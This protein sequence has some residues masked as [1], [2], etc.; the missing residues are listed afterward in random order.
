M[1]E[2]AMCADKVAI[3]TGAT[4]S[5]IGRSTALTLARESATVVVNYHNNKTAAT[6][7]VAHIEQQGGTACAIQA[8]IFQPEGCQHL[9]EATIAQF[10]R[11]DICVINPGG[12]WHPESPDSLDTAAA[13]DDIQREVT[14]V[15]HLLPLLLPH[16]YTQ[17]WG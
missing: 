2:I 15:L 6:E 3:I 1:T 9:V 17:K 8:D 5:G 14:P 13:L 12:G 10:G 16:M 11:V 4:G 7:I